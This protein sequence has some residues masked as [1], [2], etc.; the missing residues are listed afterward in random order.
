MKPSTLW[1]SETLHPGIKE[2]GLEADDSLPSDA[3]IRNVCSHT[4]VLVAKKR[5]ISVA[6]VGERTIPTKRPLLVGE[7]SVNFCG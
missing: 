2:S 1:A 4:S 3:K 7:V 6:L 5:T